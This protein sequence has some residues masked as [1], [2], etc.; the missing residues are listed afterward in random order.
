MLVNKTDGF[1]LVELVIGII[2]F[3]I[4]MTFFVSF[5]VPQAVRSVDPIFQVRAAELGQSLITE[6]ASKSFDEASDRV[7]GGIACD[8]SSCTSDENLGPEA[9]ES[10]ANYNDV[11]DYHGF[12]MPYDSDNDGDSEFTNALGNEIILDGVNLYSGFNVSVSV[13]Y[14]SNMDGGLPDTTVGDTKLITVTVT[15]P[16]AEDIIFS[17]YRKNY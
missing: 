12:V 15:T 13:M 8:T 7:G 10:R 5:I 11:D 3:S 2:V 16:N 4:A 1:T 9:G 6:I 14:D 17:S